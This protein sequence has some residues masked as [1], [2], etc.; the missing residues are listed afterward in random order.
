MQGKERKFVIE[1]DERQI[2]ELLF[3]LVK[4]VED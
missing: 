3:G 1:S 2:D 4:P